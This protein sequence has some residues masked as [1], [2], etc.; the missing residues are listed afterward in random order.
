MPIDLSKVSVAAPLSEDSWDAFAG[1]VAGGFLPAT[2]LKNYDVVFDYPGHTFTLAK[3]GV[4]VHRGTPLSISVQPTTG[5]ARTEIKIAGEAYGFMLDTGAAYTGASRAVVDGWIHEHPAWP[6]SVGAVG[7]ANMVGKQFDVMNMLVRVPELEWG[8]FRLRNVGMVSRPRGVYEQ[9][10]S[11]EMTAPIIG[12]LAGNVLREFRIEID[13]PAGMAYLSKEWTGNSHDL[14][15][16]GLILQMESSGA[17]LVSGVATRNGR[18]E[19]NGVRAGDTLL[20]V[21]SH[22]VARDSLA[23]ILQYL[24]GPVGENKRLT[25]RRGEQEITVSARVLRHPPSG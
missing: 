18:P 12:A 16:V 6:H 13:Y 9:A 11:K 24:S 19:V 21:D 23:Q 10:I 20:R 3:P 2:V 22:N 5:F 25:I 14:D 4:V 8:P 7:A 17:V 1:V 15:C